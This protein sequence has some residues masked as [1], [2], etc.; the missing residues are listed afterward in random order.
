MRRGT[1][2][3]LLGGAALLFFIGTFRPVAWAA[4]YTLD[5]STLKIQGVAK[6]VLTDANGMTLYYLV[7]DSPAHST[8]TGG[9]AQ[10]WPPLLSDSVPTVKDV[11]GGKT[12]VVKTA[13]GPQ[14]SYNGHPLYRYSGDTAP[15]QANGHG[16]AARWW[17][18]DV[19]LPRARAAG[20]TPMKGTEHSEGRGGSD[21]GMGGGMGH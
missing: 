19:D 6:Q 20:S 3:G 18:A 8:C 16:L 12:A 4:A 17:V 14:V 10:V 7:T 1:K 2:V 11:L 5:A 9:C 15:G 21:G 13:N